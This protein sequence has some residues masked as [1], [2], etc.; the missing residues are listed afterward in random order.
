MAGRIRQAD[1][2]E[3]KA[4]TNIADIIGERVAL[5]SARPR[6]LTALGDALARLPQVQ[7][8]LAR[9]TAPLLCELARRASTHPAICELL[10]RALRP[11][12]PQLPRH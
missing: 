7:D 4:R 1:V 3:V 12:P 6:D 10:Q 8:I 11:Q 2:E 5:K 9:H